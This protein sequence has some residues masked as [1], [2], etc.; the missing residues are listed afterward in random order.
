MRFSVFMPNYNDGLTI[1]R[2]LDA[3]MQQSRLP[4]EVIVFDDASTDDSVD[5]IKRYQKKYPQIQLEMNAVNT[6]GLEIA[7]R[8][9]SMLSG[10]FVYFASANDYIL[11]GFFERAMGLAEQNPLTGI[12][13]GAVAFIDHNGEDLGVVG[14]KKWQKSLF[15]ASSRYLSECLN[16]E[17]P[18]NSWGAATIYRRI[19]LLDNGGF[20]RE[21][22][23]WSDTFAARA[24]GLQYGACYI[25]S[26]CVR[27]TTNFNS[28]SNKMMADTKDAL[29]F[30]AIAESLMS[31]EQFRGIF[32]KRHVIQWALGFRLSI[33]GAR[34]F[35]ARGTGV[36]GINNISWRSK[37]IMSLF[38][39]ARWVLYPIAKTITRR[40]RAIS[41][42]D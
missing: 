7:N 11:P 17:I 19:P 8:A 16:V 4:D 37:F 12:I 21:L 41:P 39:T 5:V 36:A 26:P 27:V 13:F 32:P 1:D 29:A 30:V 14:V 31:S 2:A 20:I 24:L 40:H 35:G 38:F 9:I 25:S 33:I 34:L 23:S 6:G 28:Y 15:A 3:I 18:Q 22:G 10:D 42:A